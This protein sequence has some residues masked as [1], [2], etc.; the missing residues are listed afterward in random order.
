MLLLFAMINNTKEGIRYEY[1]I[2]NTSL[3]RENDSN[4]IG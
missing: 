4:I 1:Y 3:P 2:F